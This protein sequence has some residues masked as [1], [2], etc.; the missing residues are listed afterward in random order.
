MTT[1]LDAIC[2]D[3]DHRAVSAS[4][5][6]ALCAMALIGCTDHGSLVVHLS[7]SLQIPNETDEL[8]VHLISNGNT[9]KDQ[10]YD[11]GTP[12]RDDW[13]QVLP[14]VSDSGGL[15]AVTIAAEL[16][17]GMPGRIPLLV[18][19]SAVDAMFPA[20]ERSTSSSTCSAPASLPTA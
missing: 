16:R 8:L 18:G 5:L 1:R 7:S 13:P 12:P 10:I 3:H 9:V 14:I 20:S 15:K 6:P 2:D 19:F 4:R 17:K 11:L